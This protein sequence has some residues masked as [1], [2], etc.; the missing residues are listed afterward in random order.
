MLYRNNSDNDKNIA[1]FKLVSLQKLTQ[2]VKILIIDSDISMAARIKQFLEQNNCE[3]IVAENGC[4]GIYNAIVFKPDVI[5]SEIYLP[6]IEG[7]IIHRELNNYKSSIKTKFIYMTKYKLS[8]FIREAKRL[9]ADELLEKPLKCDELLRAI[10]HAIENKENISTDE[11]KKDISTEVYSGS[12]NNGRT[13]VSEYNYKPGFRFFDPRKV[14]VGRD[15]VKAQ[16]E[17]KQINETPGFDSPGK[18]PYEK[19]HFEGLAVIIVNLFYASHREAISFRKFLFPV[20]AGETRKVIIDLSQIEHIDSSFT[21][22]LVEASRQY[23]TQ[24]NCGIRLVFDSNRSSINPF[25]VKW[26]RK[27]FQTYDNLNYAIKCFNSS[28]GGNKKVSL[29]SREYI[30]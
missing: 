26:I 4:N 14:I 21:G 16:K 24:G 1:G 3:A 15:G 5:L 17:T 25:I 6:D 12:G 10:F 19:Y 23:G 20:L 29:S 18:R 9:G 11:N 22:V 27:N 13:E 2:K 30:M 7:F 28:G 8:F